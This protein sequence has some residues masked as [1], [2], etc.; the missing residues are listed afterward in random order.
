[1]SNFHL[2]DLAQT[3]QGRDLGYLQIV[4][5]A[6]EIEF[7][8]PDFQT[9]VNRL[10]PRL[11]DGE[12]LKNGLRTLTP[13]ARNAFYDL[14]DHQGKLPW[15]LFIRHH[16]ALR[17]MGPARR[18]RERPDLDPISPVEVLWYHG[19]IGRSFLN[20]SNGPVEYA[21]IP[22]DLLGF[23]K[24][25]ARVQNPALGQVAT[26]VEREVKIISD[27]RLL[28]DAC[29]FLAAERLGEAIGK[30]FLCQRLSNGYTEIYIRFLK[31]ILTAADLLDQTSQPNP[32]KTR[33]FLENR[34]VEAQ[35]S[36]VTAWKESVLINE[37]GMIPGLILEG[38][39]QNDPL[40]T[41]QR[42]LEFILQS[43][44]QQL[45]SLDDAQGEVGDHK[46]A[47]ERPFI[48]LG[49]FL[50]A[51]KE[52]HPD[53]QRPAGD[54][55]NWFIR[56]KETGE[57]LHGFDNWDRVD[58][59]IVRFMI[60]GPLY[61]LG[62]VDLARPANADTQ[63]SAFRLSEAANYLLQGVL[64]FESSQEPE[65]WVVQSDGTVRA[66]RLSPRKARYQLARFC[67]WERFEQD[68][69]LYRITPES[70]EKARKQTLRVSQLLNLINNYSKGAPR[71]LIQGLTRWD[72]QGREAYFEKVVVL[73]V[74]S[75]EILQALR[76]SR[77]AKF[78]G[79]P[80][81]PTAIIVNSGA[82]RRVMYVL[83]EMGYLSE[84]NI[85]E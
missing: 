83:A 50:Q 61:W 82:V 80:L 46:K 32:E 66:P 9:G 44:G 17:E 70:L 3:F 51:I 5:E 16:G 19:L 74:K 30:Q 34:R 57:F 65:T 36:L 29:T 48:S 14:V 64:R 81:G 18:D 47:P 22:E 84:S 54:Y 85:E 23:V 56:D 77:A 8:V 4:A 13:E 31:V 55:D 71:S 49:S 45:T 11:L 21:Y 59:A 62:L 41:R 25:I 12:R 27:D 42:I 33:A 40:I 58:G 72:Q 67:A 28:D 2:P 10:A 73:R 76:T 52:M 26:P 43:P 75:P 68:T 1:L 35:A 53:F 15:S 39:Y 63:V 7:N 79:D 60:V 38:E 24:V 6:W 78:L 20:T 69:Y 37:L